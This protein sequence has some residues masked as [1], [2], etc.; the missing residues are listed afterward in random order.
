MLINQEGFFMKIIVLAMLVTLTA[1]G[2]S[3]LPAMGAKLLTRPQILNIIRNVNSVNLYGAQGLPSN[4]EEVA[5]L[6]NGALQ[7]A[8]RCSRTYHRYTSR[9][10]RE[11][12]GANRGLHP[13]NIRK[14]DRT[15]VWG[16][17]VNATVTRRS[18]VGGVRLLLSTYNAIITS[19]RGQIAALISLRRLR[20]A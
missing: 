17:G 16:G 13:A 5:S 18:Y 1:G 7:R 8:S 14:S 3:P 4:A 10:G 11:A 19:H 12:E 20:V 9:R 15:A 6:V 2:S